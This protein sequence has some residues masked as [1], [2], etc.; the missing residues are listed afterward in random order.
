MR[1]LVLTDSIVNDYLPGRLAR[2]GE[3]V[4]LGTIVAGPNLQ[5]LADQSTPLTGVSA[6]SNSLTAVFKN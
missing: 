4:E 6:P 5:L 3:V 2:T 1:Y